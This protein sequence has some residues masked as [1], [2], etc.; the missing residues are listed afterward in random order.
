MKQSNTLQ[1]IQYLNYITGIIAQNFEKKSQYWNK[2]CVPVLCTILVYQYCDRQVQE[3][4]FFFCDNEKDNPIENDDE[5]NVCEVECQT[6]GDDTDSVAT[7]I[8]SCEMEPS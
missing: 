3:I 2:F 1:K 4:R 7:L 8:E 5:I 6:H